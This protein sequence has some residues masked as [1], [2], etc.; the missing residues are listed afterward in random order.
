MKDLTTVQNL[1]KKLRWCLFS[2]LQSNIF[3]R[4]NHTILQIKNALLVIYS[5]FSALAIVAQLGILTRPMVHEIEA[6]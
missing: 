2:D 3:K 4:I 6:I 1:Q 5:T